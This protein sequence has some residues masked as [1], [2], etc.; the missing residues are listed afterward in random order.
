MLIDEEEEELR[1]QYYIQDHLG[2]V[3]VTFEDKNEDGSVVS[4]VEGMDPG[5]EE[6]VQRELYYPFGLHVNRDWWGLAPDAANRTAQQY[7]YNGKELDENYGLGLHFYGARM[8]D[9]A[10]GRFTGVDPLADQFPGWSPY[11]YVMGNPVRLVDPDGMAPEEYPIVRITK[12]K[13]GNTVDQRVLGYTQAGSTVTTDLYKVE[14]T[15][16]EDPNFYMSFEVTRDAWVQE[17]GGPTAQNVAFEPKDGNI[18]HF[19]G[20]VMNGGYP[21]GNGTEALKL[22]QRGSEV[23]HAEPNQ[24]SVNLGYRN[25]AD[26]AA[27]VMIHVGGNYTKGGKPRL[28]ASE[29]C[30]GIC[31]PGNS[32]SN[33]SNQHSN[34]V[35]NAIQAQANK[36]QTDPGKILIIL[37]KRTGNEYPTTAPIN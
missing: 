34:T 14:V 26:V 27:G 28:A 7:Q 13:T 12:Q 16:T 19:T 11:N 4:N 6:V 33:P 36:S 22:T 25:K 30:F 17:N 20:K 2:N 37:E 35:M 24:T 15:D 9:A 21:R 32:P 5:T 29:G 3:V 10:V 8:Y 31:N 23:M 18:N 1:Y